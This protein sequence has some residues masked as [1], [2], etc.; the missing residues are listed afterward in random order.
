MQIDSDRLR[1]VSAPGAEKP[2]QSAQAPAD[3]R[4]VDTFNRAMEDGQHP[5][6]A[7]GRQEGS[8]RF[9]RQEGSERFQ[10][11]EGSDRFL[12]REGSERFQRQEGERGSGQNDGQ[13]GT[14]F[15]GNPLEAFFASRM[16]APAPVSATPPPA[17]PDMEL[18]GKLVERIL[19]ATPSEG[20][21]E[22]RISLGDGALRGTEIQLVRGTD[23]LLT[24]NLQADNASAFQTLVAARDELQ[25]RLEQ[26]G[27]KDVRVSVDTQADQQGNDANRRSRGYDQYMSEDRDRA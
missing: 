3:Q 11:Q 27:E 2:G 23:G 1:S 25:F 20:G 16:E 26:Q 13:P 10:Q 7:P 6:K 24:V 5:E 12:R 9:L 17:S 14:G 22:V 15:S 8:D 4:D 21:A 19:V 18:A